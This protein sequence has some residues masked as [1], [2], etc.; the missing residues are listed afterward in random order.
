MVK[1]YHH[2]RQVEAARD[3]LRAALGEANAHIARLAI[4][5]DELMRMKGVM[6]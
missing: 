6:P 5:R 1:L 3:Q 2:V 4:E